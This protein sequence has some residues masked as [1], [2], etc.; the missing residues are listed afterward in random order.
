M[1]PNREW[2]GKQA[3]MAVHNAREFGGRAAIFY[4]L[5]KV[6]EP[7]PPFACPCARC[8]HTT[9]ALTQTLTL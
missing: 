6:A 8:T 7:P 1:R 2:R 5:E 3:N 4:L 9:A